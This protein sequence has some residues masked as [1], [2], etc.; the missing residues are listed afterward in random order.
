MTLERAERE[1]GGEGGR[2]LGY[3]EL[4]EGTQRATLQLQ[5]YAGS[6]RLRSTLCCGPA[7]AGAKGRT[8]I[9]LPAIPYDDRLLVQRDLFQVVW[10]RVRTS[11]KAPR[12][13]LRLSSVE[14]VRFRLWLAVT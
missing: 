8:L 12:L 9:L 2:H 3:H 7:G 11:L 5:L 13:R 6:S 10:Q 1:A 4:R 14:S